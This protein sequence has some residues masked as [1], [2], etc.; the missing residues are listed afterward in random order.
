MNCKMGNEDGSSLVLFSGRGNSKRL[1]MS[2]AICLHEIECASPLSRFRPP[3]CFEGNKGRGD[4][5]LLFSVRRRKGRRKKQKNSSLC[6][7]TWALPRLKEAIESGKHSTHQFRTAK[8]SEFRKISLCFLQEK[9]IRHEKEISPP[10]KLPKN[11]ST[12]TEGKG[13]FHP[14]KYFIAVRTWF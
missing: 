3:N 1:Q 9:K 7:E 2:R 12:K 4:F 10:R 8:T 6:Q 11:L 13:G 14:R 5:P